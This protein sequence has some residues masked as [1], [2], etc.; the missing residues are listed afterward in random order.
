MN[1]LI[2]LKIEMS[3]GPVMDYIYPVVLCD[4]DNCV[5]VDCGYVGSLLK[6]EEALRLS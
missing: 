5:L 6:I 2:I 3:Y 4:D 1:K